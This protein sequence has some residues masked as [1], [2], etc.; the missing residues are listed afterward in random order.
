[1]QDQQPVQVAE[2]RRLTATVTLV[3]LASAY[4]GGFNLQL[5]SN[6][7]QPHQGGLCFGDSG[8]PVLDGTTILAVNSFVIN[9]NCAGAGFAYRIDQ[10][11]ILTWIGTFL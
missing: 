11:E 9:A 7:G 6:N 8:G 4:S 2:V 3:S 10:P 5:S 1:M